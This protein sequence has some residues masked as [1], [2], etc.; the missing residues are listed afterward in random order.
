MYLFIYW[1]MLL[2]PLFL[3]LSLFLTLPPFLAVRLSLLHNAWTN[4]LFVYFHIFLLHKE[5]PVF[6]MHYCKLLLNL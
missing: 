3:S 5:T 4:N 1:E 6:E 2:V